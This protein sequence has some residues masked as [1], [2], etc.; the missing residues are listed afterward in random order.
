[1]SRRAARLTARQPKARVRARVSG[2]AKARCSMTTGSTFWRTQDATS[3]AKR[4]KVRGDGAGRLSLLFP[5]ELPNDQ[6]GPASAEPSRKNRARIFK[7]SRALGQGS[8]EEG[9]SKYRWTVS[10]TLWLPA[11]V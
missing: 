7:P 3:P 2:G 10:A 5:P 11:H 1:M 8:K 9:V 6:P 4:D